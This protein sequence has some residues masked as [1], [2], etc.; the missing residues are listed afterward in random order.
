MSKFL[1]ENESPE[2]RKE[3]L[4]NSADGIV[5]E[6]FYRKLTQ[7]ELIAKK[8]AFTANA[9]KFDDIEEQKKDVVAE[10][11]EQLDPL[12]RTHKELGSEIRTGYEE[13]EGTLYKMV[14]TEKRWVSFYSETGELIETK[15][16]P[17][18]ADELQ[19]TIHMEIRTGTNDQNS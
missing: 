2:E 5:S 8:A 12:K 16:R 11:K 4:E 6:K 10:F 3:L 18:V 19:K 15:S 13:V 14:D 1:F 9:L 17:A 7:E